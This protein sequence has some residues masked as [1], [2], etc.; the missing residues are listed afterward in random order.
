MGID[1]KKHKR[2]KDTYS[3]TSS[4]SDESLHPDSKW[5]NETE[6]KRILINKLFWKF[7]DSAIEIDMTFPNGLKH[8]QFNMEYWRDI[9]LN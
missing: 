5:V 4:V 7:I 1:I 2:I 8:I 6:A 3:L 9:Q